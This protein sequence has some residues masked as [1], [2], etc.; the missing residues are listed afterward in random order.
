MS[1]LTEFEVHALRRSVEIGCA[2]DEHGHTQAVCIT[3]RATLDSRALFRGDTLTPPYDYC[4]MV[5]AVDA[6]IASRPRFIL[7][8]TLLV[9]I[10]ARV[11][12]HPMVSGL[13]I[14][15]AKTERYEGCDWIGTR[16]QLT[17]QDLAVLAPHY[18]EDAALHPFAPPA[19]A[20]P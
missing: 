20:H 18:P 8:E 7:Q 17:R 11:L 13:D 16:T 10:A 9:A 14:E 15:L 19:A 2:E 3:L 5:A 1:L 6:A 4:D 12:S